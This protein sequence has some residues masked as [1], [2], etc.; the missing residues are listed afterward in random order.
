MQY[1]HD[2]LLSHNPLTPSRHSLQYSKHLPC[3]SEAA[4]LRYEIPECIC[5]NHD[6]VGLEIRESASAGHNGGEKL[7]SGHRHLLMVGLGVP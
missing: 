3:R 6:G 5:Q 7:G 1:G 4:S 2:S